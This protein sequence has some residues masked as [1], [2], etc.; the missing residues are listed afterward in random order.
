MAAPPSFTP[1]AAPTNAGAAT[2]SAGDAVSHDADLR[3]RRSVP[4]ERGRTRWRASDDAER[5]CCC[6]GGGAGP[7]SRGEAASSVPEPA[8]T[9]PPLPRLRRESTNPLLSAPVPAPAS[10]PVPALSA[11]FQLGGS[12]GDEATAAVAT[13]RGEECS[14]SASALAPLPPLRL[15][16]CEAAM[17]VP[18][19]P[20]LALDGRTC[21]NEEGGDVTAARAGEST[22]R[23]FDALDSI[24]STSAADN[25]RER[26]PGP[27]P[28]RV[29]A[30][31]ATAGRRRLRPR[32]SACACAKPR[33][34]G[35]LPPMP[36]SALC[37]RKTETSGSES[38]GCM[39][40]RSSPRP[41]ACRLC[42]AAPRAGADAGAKAARSQSSESLRTRPAPRPSGDEDGE[43]A[44]A[45]TDTTSPGAGEK[46]RGPAR[47]A[48]QSL[49]PCGS[50][51]RLRSTPSLSTSA[52]APPAGEAAPLPLRLRPET[53]ACAAARASSVR[54]RRS[55][56][57]AAAGSVSGSA[58]RLS[59]RR[60]AHCSDGKAA[61]EAGASAVGECAET[62][63][64][65]AECDAAPTLQRRAVAGADAAEV[66]CES[67][68]PVLMRSCETSCASAEASGCSCTSG[69]A[70]REKA[71]SG[72]ARSAAP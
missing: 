65:D 60:R 5:S 21:A 46:A 2:A 32:P 34:T 24:V 10:T 18:T 56:L 43:D 9:L 72:E 54:W 67:V 64:T 17:L 39:S 40:S 25:A 3:R 33:G 29:R 70:A 27:A 50:R 52:E 30:T 41:S 23:I 13:A 1:A 62:E 8:P 7:R 58:T 69:A 22:A 42:S 61:D 35:T 15:R 47:R 31:P 12:G 53:C 66:A 44:E 38:S 68:A 6:R 20:G 49:R 63:A 59:E 4:I 14:S 71:D 57:I 26:A 37:R 16:V 11:R 36:E 28:T 55:A 19:R 51:A 45:S 48:P